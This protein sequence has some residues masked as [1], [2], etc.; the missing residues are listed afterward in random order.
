MPPKYFS[1][2]TI[3]CLKVFL[4][5]SSLKMVQQ[6]ILDGSHELFFRYGLKSVT[7]DDIARHL[8]VSKKTIYQ[9]FPEKNQIILSLMKTHLE[10]N[11][12]D[13]EKISRGSK[14]AV[15]EMIGIMD[16]IGAMF[17]RI[18]PIVFYDMQKYFPECWKNFKE[19]KENYMI[20]MIQSNMNRGIKEGLFRKSLNVMVLSRMRIEQI[21]MAMNPLIFSPD[22]YNL[23]EVQLAMLDHF[24]HGITTLKGHK[25]INKY[26]QVNED[27]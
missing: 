26:R 22:K 14:D 3:L 6:E 16:F 23:T 12:H 21:E 7:M 13:L 11:K 25:L 2:E 10:K 1:Q 18:N 9:Y 5:L 17:L 27:E 20:S 8:G 24:L 4:V 15:E 19:F